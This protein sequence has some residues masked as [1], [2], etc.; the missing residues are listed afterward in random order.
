MGVNLK[1]ARYLGDSVLGHGLT[2][3][4]GGDWNN[5]PDMI[6]QVVN[7]TLLKASVLWDAVVPTYTHG[8]S[9]RTLDY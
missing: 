7:P 2:F 4:M 5:A 6:Q 8:G 1:L 9:H 3:I